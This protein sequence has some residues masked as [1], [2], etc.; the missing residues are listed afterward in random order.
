MKTLE[1]FLDLPSHLVPVSHPP[2]PV[3]SLKNLFYLGSK[4]ILVSVTLVKVVLSGQRQSS[5]YSSPG[6]SIL[7]PTQYTY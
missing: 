5:F 1:A 2:D 6:L 4:T 3:Y 7:Y